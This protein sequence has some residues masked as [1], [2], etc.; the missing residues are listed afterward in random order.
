MQKDPYKYFRIEAAEL[1]EGLTT[2][3]LRL[4]KGPD[5]DLVTE[6]FRLAH[7]FK[8][9]SRVVRR[10]DIADIAHTIEDLLV[11]HRKTGGPFERTTIDEVL[12]LLREMRALVE[13]LGKPEEAPSSQAHHAGAEAAVPEGAA[14]MGGA[15]G[16]PQR[17][18]AYPAPSL[19]EGVAV[20]VR[21]LDR[22]LEMTLDLHSRSTS[23]AGKLDDLDQAIEMLKRVA[24]LLQ[25]RETRR[26]AEGRLSDVLSTLSRLHRTLEEDND[27]LTGALS[28]LKESATKMRLVPAKSL[29]TDLEQIAREAGRSLG[30]TLR[31]EAHLETTHL[32]AR[33]E[34]GL[35]EAL[36]HAIQNSIAHGLETQSARREANKPEEGLISLSIRRV[37]SRLLVECSDDGQGFDL[38]AIRKSLVRDGTLTAEEVSEA[39]SSELESFAAMDGFSTSTEVSAVAG[40]GVGLGAATAAV[41]RVRG[42]LSIKS[43]AG[44]G[45]TIQIDVPFTYSVV[46]ALSV[47]S[48]N[49]NALIP[50][51]AVS[52]AIRFEGKE[53]TH[54]DE[55]P[56]LLIDGQLYPYLSL[57]EALELPEQQ[58]TPNK[59][60]AVVIRL[61]ERA[62]A[63]GVDR[64]ESTRSVVVQDL[65]KHALASP[66]IEGASLNEQGAPA[67]MLAPS[68]LFDFRA[69]RIPQK[70][71]RRVSTE[72]RP[73]LVIDDSLTT[74]MLEQSILEG[75]GYEV[76]LATSGEEGLKKART[77]AYGAFIVDVEMPGMNGFEFLKHVKS[78]PNLRDIRA[79]MVTSLDSDEDRRRGAEAG[80]YA[81]MVKSDFDQERLL[82]MLGSIL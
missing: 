53:L 2:G 37:G 61:H 26:L 8:G 20:A 78:D 39:S 16:G 17:L 44:R 47:V 62:L 29:M 63:L 64:I 55:A 11:P 7:T 70:S 65:P 57:E 60:N 41:R 5:V 30:K 13:S 24:S 4:E 10:P 36:V 54:H 42:E 6:L 31:F 22:I 66:L 12:S 74:R 35:R 18:G 40:R 76:D 82:S 33:I 21:E 81:Y 45:T 14:L 69:A 71:Q 46:S 58:A 19:R 27:Q 52:Q 3:F 80:A 15:R 79:I 67:L 50:L 28:S 68:G 1:L 51:S 23:L 9:A 32:D 34:V 77:R 38:E 73:V 25:D 56:H 43:E 72:K 48:G 59:Q 49:V 75:A